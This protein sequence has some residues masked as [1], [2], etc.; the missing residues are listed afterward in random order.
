[1]IHVFCGFL[2]SDIVGELARLR[3]GLQFQHRLGE[4]GPDLFVVHYGT[5]IVSGQSL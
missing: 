3:F 5:L 1:M 4:S 2:G